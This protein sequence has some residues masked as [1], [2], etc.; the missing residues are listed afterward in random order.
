MNRQL[1]ARVAELERLF[2]QKDDRLRIIEKRIT[3]CAQHLSV[4]RK[5]SSRKSGK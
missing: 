1:S 5:K 2:S 3:S 4:P